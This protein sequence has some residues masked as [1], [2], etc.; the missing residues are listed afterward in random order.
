MLIF[1]SF[2]N[3]MFDVEI[4]KQLM[5]NWGL[6]FPWFTIHRELSCA[7]AAIATFLSS[8]RVGNLFVGAH[9]HWTK[10][11]WNYKI[12]AAPCD[13]EL[14]QQGLCK[15]VKLKAILLFLSLI[16]YVTVGWT[17]ELFFK[18]QFSFVVRKLMP[19]SSSWME[20][21]QV[22]RGCCLEPAKCSL[23]AVEQLMLK[24]H[25]LTGFMLS[26]LKI[27]VVNF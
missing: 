17:Q 6:F 2:F 11:C 4:S 23:L 19:F 3:K 15:R 12:Q 14:F 1:F 16:L 7:G 5:W 8:F 10:V 25:P 9:F 24:S 20:S 13:T 22:C 18:M 27:A 26:L 21:S